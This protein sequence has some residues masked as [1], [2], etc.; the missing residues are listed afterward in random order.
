M[1]H[2]LALALAVVL[3]GSAYAQQGKPA[4][5]PETMKPIPVVR[6]TEGLYTMMS[7]GDGQFLILNTSNGQSYRSIQCNQQQPP[8]DPR[9]GLRPMVYTDPS[10]S[11]CVA[12]VGRIPQ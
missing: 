12:A 6:A 8:A 5:T 7:L 10:R 2:Y 4:V 9:T 3:S 11:Y 1:K